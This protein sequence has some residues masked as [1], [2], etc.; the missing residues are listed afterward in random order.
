M[1]NNYAIPLG[2]SGGDDNYKE[3]AGSLGLA[4]NTVVRWDGTAWIPSDLATANANVDDGFL[5]CAIVLG[6]D[7]NGNT[8]LGFGGLVNVT[9]VI[10]SAHGLTV[11]QYYFED[12]AGAMTVTTPVTGW[13]NDILKAVDA[14]CLFVDFGRPYF[15]DPKQSQSAHQI[16]INSAGH[17][18]AL[19]DLVYQDATG[20]NFGD[21]SD[22]AK[23]PTHAVVQVIDADTF[24]IQADGYY[25]G[26]H[27]L[28]GAAGDDFFATNSGATGNYTNAFT[29]VNGNVSG[30]YNQSA[31]QLIDGGNLLIL[32]G[33]RAYEIA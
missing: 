33:K 19:L 13:N 15:A 8:I 5:S 21:N 32:T 29:A 1:A 18:F 28:I 30:N 2:G 22:I 20:W 3:L 25:K 9:D 16:I 24:C 23:I 31:F 17:G 11:G 12:L 7:A 4:R 26:A 27:G 10:G 14:D 6:D